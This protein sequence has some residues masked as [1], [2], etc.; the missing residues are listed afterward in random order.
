MIDFINAARNEHVIT[1]E[2]PIEFVHTDKKSIISQR[3]L[4]VD[5]CRSFASALRASLRQDPGCDSRR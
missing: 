1:I 5:T 4:D 3:E 2:D